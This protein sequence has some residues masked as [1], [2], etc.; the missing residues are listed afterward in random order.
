[1]KRHRPISMRE[2]MSWLVMALTAVMVVA[3]VSTGLSRTTG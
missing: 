2:R 1:M 3:V